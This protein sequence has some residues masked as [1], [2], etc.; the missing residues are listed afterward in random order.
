MEKKEATT[1]CPSNKKQWRSWLKANHNKEQS[2]WL[3]C[4]KQKSGMPTISW[5]D[6]VDE[7]LCFGWIDGKAKPIDDEKFMRFFSK[8]K[9]RSVWS[10]INKGKVQKLIDDGM[11]TKGGLA[12]VEIAKQNGSWEI[13]DAIEDLVVPEDL[14]KALKTKRGSTAFF[15]GLSKSSKKI[16]LSWV[17]LAKRP[18]T[19]QNRIREIV[20]NAAQKQKPKQFR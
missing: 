2:V 9:P 15:L 3:I 18:E 19:R 5:S 12:C 10:R 16:L 8:R 13:L 17:T 7:A 14:E 6:A 4:Y 1:F 20:E 11:M